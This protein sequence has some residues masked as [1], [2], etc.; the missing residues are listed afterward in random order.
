MSFRQA[1]H[2]A[3]TIASWFSKTVFESQFWRRYCQTFSTGFS[4]GAREGRK[5]GVMLLG[6]S[7]FLVVCHPAPVEDENGVGARGDVARDFVELKLHHVGVGV[8]QREGGPDAA[9][10]ADRAEQI[11]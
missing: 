10:R 4:S 2:A 3:S 6:T 8:G 7:S 1:A 9:S 5:I 11:G